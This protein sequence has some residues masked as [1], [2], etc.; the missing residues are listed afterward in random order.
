[1]LVTNQNVPTVAQHLIDDLASY[2]TQYGYSALTINVQEHK[3]T[4]DF[5]KIERRTAR[6]S[7]DD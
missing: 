1:M 7:I 5:R 2:L 4:L 3:V 6:L